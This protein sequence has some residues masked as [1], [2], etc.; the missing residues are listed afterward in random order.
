MTYCGSQELPPLHTEG[1]ALLVQMLDEQRTRMMTSGNPA[2]DVNEA[3]YEFLRSIVLATP[4]SPL[5]RGLKQLFVSV[6][7]NENMP[8]YQQVQIDDQAVSRFIVSML[9][10]HGLQLKALASGN[11][12]TWLLPTAADAQLL[13]T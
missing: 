11:C 9:E 2:L 3:V 4:D 8:L 6:L 13:P 1:I 5:T 12:T 7:K 10:K